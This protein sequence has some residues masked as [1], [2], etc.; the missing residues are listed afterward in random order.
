MKLN[1]FA[2]DLPAAQRKAPWQLELEAMNAVAK[3][4]EP[5]DNETRA[6]VLLWLTARF[7]REQAPAN[8]APLS[9]RATWSDERWREFLREETP[10]PGEAASD[11][12]EGHGWVKPRAAGDK[13]RSGGPGFCRHCDAEVAALAAREP[14]KVASDVSDAL[15]QRMRDLELERDLA[16]ADRDT[17]RAEARSQRKIAEAGEVAP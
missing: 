11:S 8:L 10:A 5:L 4:L 14:G 16:I 12:D 2:A 9:E 6:R 7:V 15:R 1:E 17:A 3:A 13:M